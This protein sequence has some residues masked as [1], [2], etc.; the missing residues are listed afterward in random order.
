VFLSYGPLT[1][2]ATRK[3]LLLGAGFVTRPTAE[4]L[5]KAGISVTVGE[6]Y[7]I[8]VFACPLANPNV[9]PAELLNPQ[10]SSLKDFP[11]PS[12]FPWT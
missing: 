3:V 4:E 10:R 8:L 7:L 11:M 12:P 6:C 2:F 1:E 9:K 5:D